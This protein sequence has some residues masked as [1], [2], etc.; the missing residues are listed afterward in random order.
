VYFQ[1]WERTV[2][3]LELEGVQIGGVDEKSMSNEFSATR[4]EH[5]EKTPPKPAVSFEDLFSKES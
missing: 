4:E 3:A 5:T 2:Q 1:V